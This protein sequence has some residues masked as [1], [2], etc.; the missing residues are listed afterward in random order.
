MLI[1]R[2]LGMLTLEGVGE[3]IK[4]SMLESEIVICSF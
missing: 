4:S 3:C 1:G 2:I